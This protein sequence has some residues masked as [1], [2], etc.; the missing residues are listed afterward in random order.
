MEDDKGLV[1][2]TDIVKSEVLNAKKR[3]AKAAL[4]LRTILNSLQLLYIPRILFHPCKREAL[5]DSRK[6]LAA[7]NQD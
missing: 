4:Q 7:E 3:P 6:I 5:A 2:D 1:Q